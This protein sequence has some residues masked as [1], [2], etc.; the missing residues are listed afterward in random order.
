M[1]T[2]TNKGQLALI[3]GASLLAIIWAANY[4]PARLCQLS[5]NL[6]PSEAFAL[7][8]TGRTLVLDVREKDAYDK[9][10]LPGAISVP[11]GELD[12]RIG[13]FEAHKAEEV[14][15]YCNDGSKRGPTATDKMNKAGYP[16]A[17]NLDGGIEGWRKADYQTITKH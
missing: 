11:I 16:R 7:I 5:V 2:M 14:I 4:S 8:Q 13:E 1:Q 9:G 12:R 6:K 10:H 3:A 17:K 15:V